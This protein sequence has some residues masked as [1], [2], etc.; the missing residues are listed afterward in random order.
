M[1]R[2]WDKGELKRAK[3]LID[4]DSDNG[5]NRANVAKNSERYAKHVHT[6]TCTPELRKTVDMSR[7]HGG[8]YRSS[9]ASM[10]GAKSV[11]ACKGTWKLR[12]ERP[13]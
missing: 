8:S 9:P 5:R 7:V 11:A 13:G 2:Y 3:T 10:K 1:H 12:H 6:H 4:K